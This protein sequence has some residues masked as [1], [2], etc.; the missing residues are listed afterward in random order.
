[1]S[2]AS[3][4][5]GISFIWR[6]TWYNQRSV[7]AKCNWDREWNLRG[8]YL[9]WERA[10]YN[11]ASHQPTRSLDRNCK[12]RKEVPSCRCHLNPHPDLNHSLDNLDL[13]PCPKTAQRKEKGRKEEIIWAVR[14]TWSKIDSIEHRDLIAL[15]TSSRNPKCKWRQLKLEE[16]TKNV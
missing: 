15:T 10:T 2:E 11:C 1:M 16:F 14:T 6:A 3:W 12:R 5:R 7:R 4:R 13:R 9:D 8:Y